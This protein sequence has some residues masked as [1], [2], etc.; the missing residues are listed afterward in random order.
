M[1]FRCP[2]FWLTLYYLFM[3]IVFEDA[4]IQLETNQDEDF[5][6][7]LIKYHKSFDENDRI[8]R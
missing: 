4:I 6:R 7:R 5:I 1:K 2:F 3:I 8:L